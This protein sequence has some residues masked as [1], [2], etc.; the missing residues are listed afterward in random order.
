MIEKKTALNY[1][2]VEFCHDMKIKKLLIS[3]THFKI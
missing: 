3:F 2:R 1:C